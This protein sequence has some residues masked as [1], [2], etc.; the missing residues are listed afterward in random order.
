MSL[1]LPGTKVV[2]RG[3]PWEVVDVESVGAQARYRL[4]CLQGVLLG[5]TLDLLAPFEQIQPVAAELDPKRAGRI[6]R[7]LL[8]HQAFL[9]DQALGP[10]AFLATQPGRLDIAPYQLVPVMR[11]LRMSR[12]RL[13]L[14]DG[15]GLG[16]T[17]EAG[18]ILSEMIARR[19]AHRILVVSPAGPLLDQ[20]DKELRNRFGLRFTIFRDWDSL[21]EER[22][23]LVLGGNAFDQVSYCLT[24]IDFAKQEKVLQDLERSVWH[25]VVIDE[26]HHCVRLGNTSD[27]EASRR[28]KL[29]EVLARQT[30]GLLLLTATPHD[31][32]DQ[33]FASLVELL[34][35]SLVNG[36]GELRGEAYR[37][38]VVRRL[39]KHIKN[40]QTGEPLFKERRVYPSPIRLDQLTHPT[41]AELQ[42]GVIAL[43]APRLRSAI[44]RKRFGEV[45]A[46]IALLKRSVSTAAACHSTL[47][48]VLK[49]Y[50]ALLS[51]GGE[52]QDA[53]RDRL[54][55]LRDYRSR[56]ERYGSLSFDEEQEQASLEAADIAAEV[57]GS[58][59][60]IAGEID[61]VQRDL[62]RTRD[63]QRQLED[64]EAS[65]NTLVDVAWRARDEDP[66]LS[67]V[68][69][70]LRA[71]R[72][73]EQDANVLVYTEYTDSQTAVLDY[74]A[75][76]KRRGGLVGEILVISGA[77]DERTRTNVTQRFCNEDR[78]ILVSTDATAEG[79]NLHERCHHLVHL[80]LPYNPNRLEQRNG[81]IDRYGQQFEPQVRYL[82][83]RGT[84][85]ERLLMRL[86]AK[87][88]KQ[89]SKL[90]F[91]PNT[92]GLSVTDHG[93]LTARLLEGLADEETSLFREERTEVHLVEG[94]TEDTS[95][96][97]Y[98]ELLDEIGRTVES[99][100]KATKAHSWLHE[101]GLGSEPRL[102]REV[103]D[104]RARGAKQS[105]VELLRFVREALRVDAGSVVEEKDGVLLFRIPPTWSFG[106]DGLDGMP[107]YDANARTLRIT[108]DR[109]RLQDDEKRELGYLSNA[110]PL[111]RRALD[112][113]RSLQFGG[114]DEHIDRRVS[115]A[116]SPNGR[117]ELLVTYSL[118]VHSGEERAFERVLACR[119]ARDGAVEVLDE[120]ASWESLASSPVPTAGVWERQFAEWGMSRLGEAEAAAAAS[121]TSLAEAFIGEQA[122]ELSSE[123]ENLHHWLASRADEICGAAATAQ[124]ELFEGATTPR[125]QS[126]RS[127]VERLAAFATDEAVARAR[128]AEADGVLRLHKDHAQR[129]NRR[130]NL[131]VAKPSLL[132]MLMLAST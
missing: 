12:P 90:T 85:E 131:Q 110:H 120:P 83:L 109:N 47:E 66:K 7:W 36:R 29:A 68:L 88:E 20:W 87:Y 32:F 81:R 102:Q 22:R 52:E 43:V 19:R 73:A 71:I 126:L 14:A 8:Y 50:R 127:P 103:D 101:T 105:G 53:R 124:S 26:A 21:Q 125:W 113:M 91:M 5:Q 77:D 107:G 84:F 23:K 11:S 42:R 13:L 16:K 96:K 94:E 104:A 38:H 4:R 129:L 3:L 128:R 37:D 72:A 27:G 117:S 6:E 2:A 106:R 86:I 67:G 15:V 92:L 62:R 39:K 61:Q 130:S 10:D 108:V 76:A 45:L 132:G 44:R 49:R 121:F 80:E 56:M 78:I 18:L 51:S 1:L 9:L 95:S 115:A 70:A 41:F 69:A 46:F 93:L 24:S 99:F 54:K 60:E 75:S 116:R 111:V 82:Y 17:V 59:E 112:R 25:M 57:F 58:A 65:L 74:L 114:G 55:T 89:R 100:E 40:P 33:H 79:L 34:D 31:G 98:Q 48:V 63:R 122:R 118:V 64:A 123:Q 28:R 119:F 35:P 30:D 97:A